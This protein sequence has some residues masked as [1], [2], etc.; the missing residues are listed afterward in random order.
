MAYF[1][2]LG[3]HFQY[4]FVTLGHRPLIDPGHIEKPGI[5]WDNHRNGVGLTIGMV[6]TRDRGARTSNEDLMMIEAQ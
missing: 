4:E 5:Q 6:S 3:H 1:S 2:M